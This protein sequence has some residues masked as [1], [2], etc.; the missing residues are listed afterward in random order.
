MIFYDIVC[1]SKVQIHHV[2]TSKISKK[3]FDADIKGEG[4]KS[5]FLL[6]MLS[7]YYGHVIIF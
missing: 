3:H 1:I 6:Y 4:K 2:K 5:K 7:F